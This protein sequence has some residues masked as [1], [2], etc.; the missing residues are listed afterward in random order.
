MNKIYDF[1]FKKR[2]PVQYT[3]MLEPELKFCYRLLDQ[4]SGVL[5]KSADRENRTT[6][7]LVICQLSIYPKLA[8][9]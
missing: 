9:G 2:L 7:C 4:P 8:F 6:F 3:S 5:E 1:D